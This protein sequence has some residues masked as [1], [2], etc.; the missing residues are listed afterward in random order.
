M[1][2]TAL[3][4]FYAN[5]RVAVPVGENGE[6]EY[7]ELARVW[8]GWKGRRQYKD[9]EFDP[10]EKCG[11]DVFNLFGKGYPLTPKRGDWSIMREHIFK[12]ICDW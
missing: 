6:K 11:P 8:M 2:K 4:D 3:F 5:K 1:K 9:V 12:V 7:K 10:A